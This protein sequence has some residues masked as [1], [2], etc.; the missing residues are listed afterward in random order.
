MNLVYRWRRA[1][2]DH[3]GMRVVVGDVD[4]FDLLHNLL[5]GTLV[6]RS[7][8]H[9]TGICSDCGRRSLASAASGQ[10][11]SVEIVVT[12]N[13]RGPQCRNLAIAV[14]SYEVRLKAHSALDSQ[15]SGTDG[16]DSRLRLT[17]LGH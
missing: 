1:T 11:H 9:R 3:L 6:Q 10:R 7:G 13:T 4:I 8:E 12:Y 14:P 16:A 2:Q 5:R 15:V 17:R